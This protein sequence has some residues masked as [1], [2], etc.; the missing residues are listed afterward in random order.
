[1]SLS[2][3]LGLALTRNKGVRLFP[4]AYAGWD[5]TKNKGRIGSVQGPPSALPGYNFTRAST[6]Y[7]EDASGNLV[8]FGSGVPRITNKGVLIEESRTNL[9][10]QSSDLSN[11][12]WV[13]GSGSGAT[14]T[15]TVNYATAPDG[16]NTATL[17]SIPARG[18]STQPQYFIQPIT[19]ASTA[20]YSGSW[21][22]KAATAPDVGQQLNLWQYDG[23][24]KNKVA[25]TLT[26]SWQRVSPGVVSTLTA[27]AS[28][29]TVSIGRLST[30]DGGVS[31]V[32]AVGVLIWGPQAEAGSF[33]T[34][35]IPTTSAS[36][37]RPADMFYYSGIAANP[38]GTVV[39]SFIPTVFLPYRRIVSGPT[40]GNFVSN[41]LLDN[42]TT[43]KVQAYDIVSLGITT[44]AAAL[45]TV[46][47]AG[48]RYNGSSVGVSLN[49]GAVATSAGGADFSTQTSYCI[50]N[51]TDMWQDWL[52]GY[53]QRMAIYPFA[54]TDAQLQSLSLG[55]FI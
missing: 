43:G 1:M 29:E 13:A 33:P 24:I 8:L 26:S 14:P 50:G 34:S 31:G 21:Y 12:V 36:V 5:F 45:N 19:L 46:N 18:V 9:L 39:A 55:N 23:A 27:G 4:Q 30:V 16:T 47:V 28:R 20:T 32:S 3:G 37:T 15:K 7:A 52:N 35:Y 38:S 2:L 42:S 25:V 6:G 41:L 11:A 54:A 51:S 17:L 40:G 49:G 10:L 44:N 22:I 53:V 48:M